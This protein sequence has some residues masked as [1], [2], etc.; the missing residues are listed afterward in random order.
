MTSQNELIPVE[1]WAMLTEKGGLD[2]VISWLPIEQ[3]AK[4][5][6]SLYDA[7]DRTKQDL[8]EISGMSDIMRGQ[9][10]PREKAA[11][12]RIKAQFGS[13]R[14]QEKQTR[15]AEF[16]RDLLRLQCE[17]IAEQFSAETLTLMTGMQVT[18]QHMELMR[19][20]AVRSFRIDIETDSTVA[21][22]E[23]A[24]KESRVE[25][26]NA[27]SSFFE[28]SVP[29]SQAV[30][31]LAPLLGQMLL[32]GVRGFKAGRELESAIEQALDQ[33]EQAAQQ[34]QQPQQSQE[35]VKAQ[36]EAQKIQQQMQMDQAKFGM[37]MQREQQGQII[38]LQKGQ[39]E[40]ELQEQRLEQGVQ[41]NS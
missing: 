16:L 10:D 3:L 28:K 39:N 38:E 30:P 25:F 26:L 23:Q 1:N 35:D 27:M 9:V 40:L 34:P 18:E 8:Y 12:S 19:N 6:L 36:A 5:L 20:D 37:E 33:M 24:E 32:F 31:Q 7:R 22:D 2:G 11:Q 14:F 29:L 4:V 21:V 15:F 17:V 13:L 41:G